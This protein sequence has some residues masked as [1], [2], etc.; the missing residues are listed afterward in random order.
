MLEKENVSVI[1]AVFRSVVAQAF[2]LSVERAACS[3]LLTEQEPRRSLTTVPMKIV[4]NL[5]SFHPHQLPE[6]FKRN[7]RKYNIT[8]LINFENV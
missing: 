2:A 4:A 5:K 1:K 6:L 7:E 8:E 3:L